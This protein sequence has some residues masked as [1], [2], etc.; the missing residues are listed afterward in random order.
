MLPAPSRRTGA[1][2]GQ[3][4]ISLFSCPSNN[5]Q[6]QGVSLTAPPFPRC[7]SEVRMLQPSSAAPPGLRDRAAPPAGAELSLQLIPSPLLTWPRPPGLGSFAG[8]CCSQG[9][10]LVRSGLARSHLLGTPSPAPLH[11]Q[12]SVPSSRWLLPGTE[13]ALKPSPELSPHWQP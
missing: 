6:V 4:N 8:H 9:I 5:C 10:K 7:P 1:G 2:E 11:S 3:A 12:L 13:Q